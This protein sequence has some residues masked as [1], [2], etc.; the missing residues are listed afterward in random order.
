MDRSMRNI[1]IMTLVVIALFLALN[2]IVRR[3]AFLDWWPVL[4][5]LLLA[6]LLWWWDRFGQR[7]AEPQ[8]APE[9]APE[10]A[11]YERTT[12][13]IPAP[14]AHSLAAEAPAE[15]IITVEAPAST[16]EPVAEAAPVVIPEPPEPAPEPEVSAPP[17]VVRSAAGPDDLKVVEGI[18]PKME[19][20]LHTAGIKT[21]EQLAA[22]SEE[23]IRAALYAA[24]MRF[25]PS[26][27]TWAE[28]AAFAA[29]GDWD[30]LHTMQE[31][32]T[33]GRRE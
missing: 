29:R 3:A 10:P 32:L 12:P 7:Q 24:G 28:Q 1:T 8:A 14:S 4:L 27:V 13:A 18:G 25:A 2:Q 31:K 19:K 30:G 21:F 23:Q 33:A 22:A 16:A 15:P 20:A 26:L 11:T 17:A 5:L 9:P 6:L